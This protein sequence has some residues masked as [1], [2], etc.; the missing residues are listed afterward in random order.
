M[1]IKRTKYYITEN[2]IRIAS[3]ED[4][5]HPKKH[6]YNVINPYAVAYSKSKQ[7]GMPDGDRD[8]IE[9]APP[10]RE[11]Q[12]ER[13]KKIYKG[14]EARAYAAAWASYKKSKL[15][16]PQND[17]LKGSGTRSKGTIKKK[18]KSAIKNKRNRDAKR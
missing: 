6:G 8:Q 1:R 18:I 5:I 9:S 16:S 3:T 17:K 11:A 4:E 7:T 10:G 2:G 14:D 12:V 13:F 15:G